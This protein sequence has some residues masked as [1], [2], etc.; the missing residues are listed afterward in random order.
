MID[1]INLW[2]NDYNSLKHIDRNF[3]DE[4]NRVFAHINYDRYTYKL[5]NPEN[6]ENKAFLRIEIN[7][8]NSFI[9]IVGS[10]R[11]W[12]FGEFSLEDFTKDNFRDA[13]AMLLSIFEI[14]YNSFRE[15]YICNIEIGLNIKVTENCTNIR[16]MIVG[17]KSSR[18]KERNDVGYKAFRPKSRSKNKSFSIKIY[19]KFLEIREKMKGNGFLKSADEI[20]FI[21]ENERR[22]W[23]RVELTITKGKNLTSKLG[24]KSIGA[25]LE[26]FNELYIYFWED[27]QQLQFSEIYNRI[28]EF[29]PENKSDKEFMDFIKIA[30]IHAIGID[31]IRQMTLKLKNRG[32]RGKIKNFYEHSTVKFSGYDNLAFFNNVMG[33]IALVLIKS[34]QVNF[35]K[36]IIPKFRS[37][38]AYNTIKKNVSE[39]KR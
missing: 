12:Y 22:N 3:F 4:R 39:S 1:N 27:I 29:D 34:G 37:N 6:R 33:Q 9:R 15:F 20:A 28:P 26:N 19:D 7:E 8:L 25:L 13:I 17:Y 10:I 30:G 21:K 2:S 23:L 38:P 11:K 31:R 14:P 35:A 18:Y 24:Y 16:N 36:E 5:F 32:M